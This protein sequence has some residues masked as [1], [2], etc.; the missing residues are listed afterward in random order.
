MSSPP[1]R[2]TGASA[3]PKARKA[4]EDKAIAV[5]LCTAA[6]IALRK[7]RADGTRHQRAR[8]V[9]GIAEKKKAAAEREL[10]SS[11]KKHQAL[12][13][14]RDSSASSRSDS[15]ESLAAARTR[16]ELDEVALRKATEVVN[17]T[18]HSVTNAEVTASKSKMN[19]I[20]AAERALQAQKIANAS[21]REAGLAEPFPKANEVSDTWIRAQ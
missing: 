6:Q 11:R 1:V 13:D 20:R 3:E 7:T 17:Q 5:F 18:A 16:V 12:V 14:P 19:A 9:H 10:E 2:D 15:I 8:I 21:A 4:A